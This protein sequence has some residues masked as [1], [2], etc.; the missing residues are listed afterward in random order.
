MASSE[1]SVDIEIPS[2]AQHLRDLASSEVGLHRYLEGQCVRLMFHAALVCLRSTQ[3]TE[4]C[5][6]FKFAE[7]IRGYMMKRPKHSNFSV[8]Q[9]RG[10]KQ[11]S[12]LTQ[13]QTAIPKKENVT[14]KTTVTLCILLII[15]SVNTSAQ[16]PAFTTLTGHWKA[17]SSVCFS[18][19]GSL[20]TSGSED[21]TIGLWDVKTG[22]RLRTLEGH[23]D[24]VSSV[25]F[26]PDGSLLAS[27][28]VDA[29]IGLWDVKI[30]NLLRILTGH[31]DTVWSVCFSPDGSL[32]ASGSVDDTI[33]LWD[34]KTGS[35]LNILRG[36]RSSVWSVCF[37]PDGS[38]LAS[39]SSN[40]T[41]GL[42]KVPDTR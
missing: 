12:H 30:G 5:P 1:S 24:T 20:L 21:A 28:S 39:G 8:F 27:G 31:S 38:L 6:N 25:C 34:V 9:K 16:D 33:G 22:N 23:S 4:S 15:F 11:S 19:D 14:M 13:T 3:P 35:N 26:S 7:S 41:I 32:L 42:W 29:T 10:V 18:P 40:D 36:H 17:V 2:E 37:S